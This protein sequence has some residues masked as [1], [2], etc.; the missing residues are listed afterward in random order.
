MYN[1]GQRIVRVIQRWYGCN[2]NLFSFYF[3]DRKWFIRLE[4]EPEVKGKLQKASH[5]VDPELRIL[6]LKY[7]R[8]YWSWQ[9]LF[10]SWAILA[11]MT[12]IVY[13]P[14]LMLP[15]PTTVPLR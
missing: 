3:L 10:M 15:I 8:T 13:L 7:L 12:V 5:L 11:V 1:D 4:K 9:L 6:S 2:V 14:L